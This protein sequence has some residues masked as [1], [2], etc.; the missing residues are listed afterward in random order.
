M[1]NAEMPQAAAAAITETPLEG[2]AAVPPPQPPTFMD[3]MKN[4]VLGM[5]ERTRAAL[6]GEYLYNGNINW[7]FTGG[8]IDDAIIILHYLKGYIDDEIRKITAQKAA[9]MQRIVEL[10]AQGQSIEISPTPPPTA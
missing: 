7:V 6:F 4:T 9:Q 2:A 8:S 1:I 10:T 3:K 5:G